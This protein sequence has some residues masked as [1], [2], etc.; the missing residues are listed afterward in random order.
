M[1]NVPLLLDEAGEA[2]IATAVMMSHHGFRRDIRR[3]G[4]ALAGGGG[5]LAALR[6]EWRSFRATLHGHHHAED[7]GIFPML[8]R[9]HEALRRTLERLGEDH[10]RIDPL[11]ERGDGAFD[12]LPRAVAAAA[13]VI[14]QLGALLDPH[15]AT[16]EA[17]VIPHLRALKGFPPPASSEEAEML[18][19]G[20]AWA[21]HGI[22]P[23]VLE[24]VY[25]MLQPEVR[26]RLP[27]AR[28]AFEQRWRRVWGAGAKV[29]PSF[30]PVPGPG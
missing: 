20:F 11:L 21:C 26:D 23:E 15:L 22:A 1:T 24:R 8:A 9:E 19:Q 13:Q 17:E 29:T 7:T 10:R 28:A 27:A 4:A 12:D 16:E 30:T 5:D 6:D 18:T 25:T 3:F 14:S 2:S